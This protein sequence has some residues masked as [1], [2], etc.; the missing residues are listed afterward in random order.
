MLVEP[1][2]EPGRTPA[3]PEISNLTAGLARG[4]LGAIDAGRES[5]ESFEDGAR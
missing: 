3:S 5:H 4:G 1:V 2:E